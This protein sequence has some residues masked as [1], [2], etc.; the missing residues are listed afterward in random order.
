[1]CEELGYHRG[2]AINLDNI[3]VTHTI[4]GEFDA[5]VDCHLQADAICRKLGETALSAENQHHLGNAYAGLANTTRSTR[6]FRESLAMYRAVGSRRWE[7]V[8]LTDFGRMLATAGHPGFAR[9]MWETALVTM[10][11]LSDPRAADVQAALAG[12]G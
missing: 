7:A 12:L 2:T 5:A 1:M 9:N 4:A 8:V 3:G 10:Q 6:A 11:E